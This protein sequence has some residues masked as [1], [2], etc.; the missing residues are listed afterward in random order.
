[1]R[2]I[3]EADARLTKCQVG[4][5]RDGPANGFVKVS[6]SKD[7]SE[8]LLQPLKNVSARIERNWTLQRLRNGSQLID[9]VA[10]VRMVMRDD[11]SVDGRDFRF[12]ELLADVGAA[13]DEQPFLFALDQN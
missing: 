9:A 3:D 12:E 4:T 11:H 2:L 6:A 8:T 10:M 5:K 7:V 13:V 1:M